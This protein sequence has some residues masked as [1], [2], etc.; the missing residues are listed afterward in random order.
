GSVP[1]RAR[2]RALLPWSM[3][4][5]VPTTIWRGVLMAWRPAAQEP[6]RVSGSSLLADP[7]HLVDLLLEVLAEQ[8]VPLGAALRKIAPLRGDLAADRLLHLLLLDQLGLEDIQDS[9]ADVVEVAH[10]LDVI[11]V[12][13]GVD[14][15]VGQV[16]A[17]LVAEL[18]E[19]T[20]LRS[21]ASFDFTL[22]NSSW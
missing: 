7:L 1:V 13:H 20:S 11:V 10:E 2:T 17:A 8:E 12:L 16:H 4:P 15:E 9:Q 14:Q 19:I 21:R 22:R 6:V 5:A 18:H 3:W